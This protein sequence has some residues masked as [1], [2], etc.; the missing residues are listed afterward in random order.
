MAHAIRWFLASNFF[1]NSGDCKP[2]WSLNSGEYKPGTAP[3]LATFLG[4]GDPG[5]VTVV[6][7]AGTGPGRSEDRILC[8]PTTSPTLAALG[9]ALTMRGFAAGA[10]IRPLLLIGG[11]VRAGP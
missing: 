4:I 7:Q 5:A 11:R 9:L 10:V 2:C 8:L 3:G 6:V 1:F